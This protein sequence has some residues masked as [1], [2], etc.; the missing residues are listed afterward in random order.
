MT[1]F[2][3]VVGIE[4]LWAPWR[5][6]YVSNARTE[7]SGC[8]LCVARDDIADLHVVERGATTLTILN[9]FPYTSGHML[10]AP[11]R[12]VE[13]LVDATADEAGAIMAATQRAIRA[14]TAALAP[15]GFNMGVNQGTVAGASIDHLHIHVVPR[16]SGDTNFVPV[17]AD[18]RVLPEHLA[19]SANR[20]R[21]AF[22]D[23][24]G[25]SA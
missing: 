4:Q 21:A 3:E 25:P 17:L 5:M 14:A 1:A 16:W 22:A 19:M 15:D 7:A 2:T 18:V 11:C 20:L 13:Q 10:I 8:F 9:R 6:E 24:T 12:H 23:L